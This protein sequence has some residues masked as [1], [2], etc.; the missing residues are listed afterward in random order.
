MV[1][2]PDATAAARRATPWSEVTRGMA[3]ITGEASIQST[4]FMFLY[5]SSLKK[6]SP[7]R[8]LHILGN[9]FVLI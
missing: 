9:I 5:L 4:R 1:S 7:C 6:V 2:P 3:P 8:G